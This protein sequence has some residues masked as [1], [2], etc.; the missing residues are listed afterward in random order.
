LRQQFDKEDEMRERLGAAEAL[1]RFKLSAK[2]LNA[3][4]PL[5]EKASPLEAS[6]LLQAFAGSSDPQ[7]GRALIAALKTAS[8][9]ASLSP[10]R[11][12]EA[13]AHYPNDVQAAA[14]ELLKAHTATDGDRAAVLE[15]FLTSTQPGDAKRGEEI[16]F[17]Q[18]AACAAC[19]R[20]GE[21]GE[22]IG[23]DLSKIGAIRNRRDLAEAI[24]FPSASLARGYE[25]FGVMTKDGQVHSGIMGRQTATAIFLRTT[26]RAEVRVARD[27][28]EQL[29][30]SATSIMPQ[31]LDKTLSPSELSDVIAF[32]ES[33]R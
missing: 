4:A 22:K 19:H 13:I 11:V 33:L 2:H 31:G 6:W 14:E 7:S 12:R 16:F 20:V 5:L 26:D 1:G 23:P 15:V 32:L 29:V 3:V 10:A 8:A 18:R 28:I 21:R 24:L 9:T 30:P 25:S 27:D 17:G